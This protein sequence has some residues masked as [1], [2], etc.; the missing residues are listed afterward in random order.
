MKKIVC[1]GDSIIIGINDTWHFMKGEPYDIKAEMKRF[2]KVYRE[3][4]EKLCNEGIKCI[5][6]MEPFVLPY[7]EDRKT[8]RE[9]LDQRIQIIRHLAK[10]Y[11]CHFVSLDGILNEAGI[12]SCFEKYSEDGV[13]PT[14]EGHQMIATQWLKVFK[15]K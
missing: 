13:H 1:I 6:I 9:D 10:E 3:I 5:I 11:N 2:E 14:R 7:P 15:N 8:W 12:N 4:I